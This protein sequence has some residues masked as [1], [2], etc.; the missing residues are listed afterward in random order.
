[1]H[2]V[3]D[4]GYAVAGL[5]DVEGVQLDRLDSLA[6]HTG[7]R[8]SLKVALYRGDGLPLVR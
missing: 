4:R 8:W 7:N 6:F 5:E 3:E 2:D 1:M